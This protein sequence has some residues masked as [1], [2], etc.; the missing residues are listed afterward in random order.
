MSVGI[1]YVEEQAQPVTGKNK[2]CWRTLLWH[3]LY[4]VLVLVKLSHCGSAS[5]SDGLFSV[6][7]WRKEKKKTNVSD[8][9]YRPEVW[10]SKCV[11]KKRAHTA[12]WRQSRTSWF[13]LDCVNILMSI[14]WAILRRMSVRDSRVQ[15][16]MEYVMLHSIP[17]VFVSNGCG[18]IDPPRKM[19]YTCIMRWGTRGPRFLGWELV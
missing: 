10:K 17:R 4:W 9:M 3:Y 13:C 12:L 1:I 5:L 8:S 19:M 18:G 11:S 2:H 7:P 15:Q 14:V 6:S 16:V